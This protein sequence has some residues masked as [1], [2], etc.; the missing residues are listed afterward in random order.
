MK[1]CKKMKIKIKHYSLFNQIKDGHYHNKDWFNRK[2]MKMI[3]NQTIFVYKQ[4]TIFLFQSKNKKKGN[5]IDTLVCH[6]SI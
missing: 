5:L 1:D 2:L 6:N 3:N 4:I